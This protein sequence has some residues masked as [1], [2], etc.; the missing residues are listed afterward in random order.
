M[1]RLITPTALILLLAV[2]VTG[3]LAACAPVAAP[4]AAPAT[5]S[6]AASP[7]EAAADS[8]QATTAIAGTT[9]LDPA[10]AVAPTQLTIPALAL[11]LP[12]VP[13]DWTI[14]TVEGERVTRW[15]IPDDALGWHINSAPAGAVGNTLLSGHQVKG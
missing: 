3:L 13:M 7:P 2:M 6:G 4:T 10:D 5:D 12:V 9:P 14:A 15:Q 11:E 1:Q 8:P